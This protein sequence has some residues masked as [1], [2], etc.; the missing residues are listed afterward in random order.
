MG[1]YR[2]SNYFYVQVN[3]SKWVNL[4]F[5]VK[6]ITITIIDNR[7]NLCYLTLLNCEPIY[8]FNRYILKFDEKQHKC[9]FIKIILY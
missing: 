1:K 2:L 7:T 8:K 4:K 9:C 6:S 3:I 5:D